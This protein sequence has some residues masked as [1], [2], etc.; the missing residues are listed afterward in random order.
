MKA[1]KVE[2]IIPAL[3]TPMNYD[4]SIDEYGLRVLINHVISGGVHGVFVCGSQGE[5]FAMT[6]D[7]KERVISIAVDECNGRVPVYVGTGMITTSQSIEMTKIAKALGADAVSVVT[8]Y[9]IK[10][11][12]EELIDHYKAIADSADGM[13]V[14]L[15][16]NVTRT[17]VGIDVSTVKNLAE[18]DNIVGIKDSSADLV[19][20]MGY[21]NATRGMNFSVLIGNDA[22]ILAG[23]MLGASGAVA[24]TANVAPSLIVDIYNAAK[25]GDIAK[26]NEAQYKVFKIRSAFSLGTFP[27]VIKEALNMLGL[28]AGPARRPIK[29]LDE[30]KRL[31]LKQ[32]LED[33]GLL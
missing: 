13:P 1:L 19:L 26:A 31:I 23:L 20:T 3:A 2:G 25:S 28:P 27:V 15:Y 33:I 10:P 11:S 18:I 17:G 5:S 4:E 9:Y 16:N 24:A 7:E 6:L 21:I 12:Q 8:P 22:S 14:L 29:P 32:I 30:K